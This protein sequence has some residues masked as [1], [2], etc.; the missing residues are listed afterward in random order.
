MS[1]LRMGIASI[2]ASRSIAVVLRW[3]MNVKSLNVNTP[4][5]MLVSSAYQRIH[6]SARVENTCLAHMAGTRM[7]LFM[8][9][10]CVGCPES[11]SCL[12][13]EG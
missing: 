4:S 7:R 13:L 6:L 12:H 5:W 1:H 3:M 8:A 10:G 9:V 11:Y 2:S